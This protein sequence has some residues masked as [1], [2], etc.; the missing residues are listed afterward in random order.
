MAT[1]CRDW[2]AA[3]QATDGVGH[4]GW[5]LHAR[6]HGLGLAG[7]GRTAPLD[8]AYYCVSMKSIPPGHVTYGAGGERAWNTLQ[9]VLS[10]I[11]CGERPCWAAM[12]V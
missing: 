12:T 9:I 6:N 2:Y 5:A 11:D 3:F 1:R 8:V 7:F 4:L 10:F